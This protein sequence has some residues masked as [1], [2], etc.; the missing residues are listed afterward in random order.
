LLGRYVTDRDEAAFA[1]LLRRQGPMVLGV[2]NRVLRNDA[3][4]ED[5]FQA[6]FL[7]LVRKAHTV[8]P[9]GMVSNWRYGVAHNTAPQRADQ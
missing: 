7:G 9:R 1:A 4:V 6:T 2:C 8:V 5:A 3:D